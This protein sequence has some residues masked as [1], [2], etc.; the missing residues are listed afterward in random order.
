L[1]GLALA[2]AEVDFLPEV[3]FFGVV[4]LA[5][6]GVSW[7]G[8]GRWTLPTWAANGLGLLIAAASAGWIAARMGDVSANLMLQDVPVTAALVPYLGPVLMALLLVRLFRPRVPGDFWVLQGLGL[9]QVALGCVLTS[10]TL[11]G[12]VLLAYLVAALC[13]LAAHE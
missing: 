6:V 2:C 11:F 5:L 8:A 4:Y 1:S 7:W 3:P 10:S 9:L 12:V 13:A